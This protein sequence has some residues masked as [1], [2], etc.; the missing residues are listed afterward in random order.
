[1]AAD[2]ASVAACR[3]YS[4]L[5]LWFGEYSN[6]I[7]MGF[8]AYRRH[9][10]RALGV[11]SQKLFNTPGDTY[12]TCHLC[13]QT[14]LQ[15]TLRARN[16]PYPNLY[17]ERAEDSMFFVQHSMRWVMWF[18]GKALLTQRALRLPYI[19]LRGLDRSYVKESALIEHYAL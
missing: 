18:T 10:E 7:A 8:A 13:M 17:L 3:P 16:L 2:R 5:E 6:A 15:H 9:A 1:M 14:L 19:K 12:L 4:L 11:D